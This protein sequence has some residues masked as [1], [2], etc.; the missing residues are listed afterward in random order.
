MCNPDEEKENQGTGQS[1]ASQDLDFPSTPE[2]Q[3]RYGEDYSGLY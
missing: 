3:K 1:D 2:E